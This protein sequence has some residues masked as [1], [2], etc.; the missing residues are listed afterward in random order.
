MET[1]QELLK[2]ALA[3]TFAMYLKSHNYH[4]NVFGPNFSQFHDFF[5]ALYLELH[6]A[7]DP[8]AEEIRTLDTF[9]PGSMTRF[10]QLTD[11]QCELSVPDALEMCRRLASDNEKVLST[12]NVCFKLADKFEK[13]GLAD[14]LTAR[15]DAHEKHG[16]ML[17]SYTK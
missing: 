3:D 4:W 2:K 8:M 11:I 9:V 5:G 17:R 16:W 1:L 15:I 7:I 6:A 10:L 13:Q 14:F 12:L